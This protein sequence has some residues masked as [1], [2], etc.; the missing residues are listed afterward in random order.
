[1]VSLEPL[2]NRSP[3][4]VAQELL[5]GTSAEWIVSNQPITI[6]DVLKPYHT[7]PAAALQAPPMT[8]LPQHHSGDPSPAT[9]DTNAL[10]NENMALR[11]HIK[12][13]NQVI[14][15]QCVQLTLATM[16]FNKAKNQLHEKARHMQD[17]A[18]HRL[19]DGKA[20]IVTGP[21]FKQ[22]VKELEDKCQLEKDEEAVH[23]EAWVAR[24]Q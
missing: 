2:D 6:N 15:S 18:R 13:L 21:E 4:Q 23:A 17:K 20:Q 14:A 22:L 12:S 24:E 11:Q 3:Q 9:A 16:A 19:F 1:M 7:P 10:I 8:L 5:Q